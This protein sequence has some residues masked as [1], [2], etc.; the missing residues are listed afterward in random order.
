MDD[1]LFVVTILPVVLHSNPGQE[2]LLGEFKPLSLRGKS[3]M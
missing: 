2:A 3:N 1:S